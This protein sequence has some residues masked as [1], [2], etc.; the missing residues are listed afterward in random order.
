V[1]KDKLTIKGPEF[2]AQHQKNNKKDLK[3]FQNMQ[4]HIIQAGD[5]KFNDNLGYVVRL[6][7]KTNKKLQMNMK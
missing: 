1:V 3:L 5:H 6:C 7:L 2:N 4:T